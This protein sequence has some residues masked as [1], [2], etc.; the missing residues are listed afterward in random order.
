MG[1]CKVLKALLQKTPLQSSILQRFVDF[2]HFRL[3]LTVIAC[4]GIAL[5]LS[6]EA[7][8]LALDQV[9]AQNSLGAGSGVIPVSTENDVFHFVGTAGQIVGFESLGMSAAFDGLLVGHLTSPSGAVIFDD[10]FS[11]F[12]SRVVLTEAGI[13]TFTI[14]VYVPSNT[15]I[16]TYS[17][18]IHSL[19]LDGKFSIQIGDLVGVDSPAVGAG[20]IEVSG[21]ED[22]YTFSATSGQI[23][24]FGLNMNSCGRPGRDPGGQTGGV[25][26]RGRSWR[27]SIRRS[28]SHGTSV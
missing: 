2:F 10:Y 28:G 12:K 15:R 1:M 16:G 23:L 18:V 13:Y 5:S 14:Y 19:P 20:K 24:N 8:D 17:F 4:L 3:A 21:S 22:S 11:Q 27:G 9:V 7:F 26:R 6:G 25:K